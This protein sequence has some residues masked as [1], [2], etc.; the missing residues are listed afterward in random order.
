MPSPSAIAAP[1]ARLALRGAAAS[2]VT[3]ALVWVGAVLIGLDS[4]QAPAAAL[5]AATVALLSLSA[6]PL[7]RLGARA[8][9]DAVIAMAMA[10]LAQRLMLGVTIFAAV[11]RFTDLPMTAYAGGLAIGLVASLAGEMVTAARDPRFFWID[12]TKASVTSPQPSGSE[13]QHA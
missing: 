8:G 10:A 5:G 1:E 11:W 2:V 4:T 12:A 6:L 9:N 7:Y 13:R 3:A